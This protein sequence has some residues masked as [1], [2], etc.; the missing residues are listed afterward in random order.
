MKKIVF[1]NHKGGVG[2]ST[3]TRI[4]AEILSKHEKVLIFDLDEQLAIANYFKKKLEILKQIENNELKEAW[5][6]LMGVAN[7]SDVIFKMNKNLDYIA[8]TDKEILRYKLDK[9]A[10]KINQ[11]INAIANEYKYTFFDLAPNIDITALNVFDVV[12]E[13]YLILDCEA[14]SADAAKSLVEQGVN[15]KKIKAIIPNKWM[16]AYKRIH[17]EVIDNFTLELNLNIPK[18]EPIKSKIA[19]KDKDRLAEYEQDFAEIIKLIKKGS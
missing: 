16:Y 10:S 7:K 14:D 18:T 1:F 4:I 15:A 12:D 2:K 17:N 8:N 19:I 11:K 13:I 3:L 6:Y 9:N 5:L